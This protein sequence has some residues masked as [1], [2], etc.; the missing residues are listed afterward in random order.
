MNKS[1]QTVFFI[2]PEYQDYRIK[3]FLGAKKKVVV[4]ALECV[5][6]LINDHMWSEGKYVFVYGQYRTIK[7]SFASAALNAWIN[8]NN[9]YTYFTSPKHLLDHKFPNDEDFISH[10]DAIMNSPFL[11]IDDLYATNMSNKT[12]MLMGN[13]LE[14]FFRYRSGNNFG[15]IITSKHS[16]DKIGQKYGQSLSSLLKTKIIGEF[17]FDQVL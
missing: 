12:D 1:L 4:D 7:T 15:G 9:K 13:V 14:D 17:N 8:I 2:P 6:K 3:D 5:S 16:L 10:Y 11:L